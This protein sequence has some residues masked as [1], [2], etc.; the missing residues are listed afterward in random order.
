M[1][2]R[3]IQKDDIKR[4]LV[5]RLGF[6]TDGFCMTTIISIQEEP[7]GGGITWAYLARPYAYAH[8][9]F[10]SKQPLLGCEVIPIDINS[11]SWER[12]E[13]WEERDSQLR[14]MVT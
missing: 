8:E 4:G 14:T 6:M 13:V 11:P 2:W 3:K 7:Y 5:V 12:C 9:N 10:N 1:G